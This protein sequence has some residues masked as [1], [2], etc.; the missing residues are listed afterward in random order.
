MKALEVN[1]MILIGNLVQKVD[2]CGDNI[3]DSILRPSIR[4]T[5]SI[6]EE[7]NGKRYAKCERLIFGKLKEI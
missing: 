6:K 4:T 1:V 3:I 5:K 2:S 7:Y